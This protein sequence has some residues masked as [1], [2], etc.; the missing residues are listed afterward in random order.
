MKSPFVGTQETVSRCP[1]NVPPAAV[2]L[3]TA[4]PELR[5]W[6]LP[7]LLLRGKQAAGWLCS[8][9]GLCA[10]PGHR[11]TCATGC[12]CA[13]GVNGEREGGDDVVEFSCSPVPASC[14]V[15]DA[16]L[17]VER[18]RADRSLCINRF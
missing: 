1:G 6:E 12:P 11:V 13:D 14:H 15:R 4:R 16:G 3:G 2:G 9:H 7:L 10:L 17:P 18:P 5:A 8:S